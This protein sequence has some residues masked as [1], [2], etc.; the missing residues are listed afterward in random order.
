MRWVAPAEK[1]AANETLEEPLRRA[2]TDQF[3][4]YSALGIR[5]VKP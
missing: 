2:A 3:H 5:A 1:D 4:A